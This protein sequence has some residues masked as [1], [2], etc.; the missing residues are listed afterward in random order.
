MKQ[1]EILIHATH[2]NDWVHESKFPFV[3][4]IGFIRS[5]LSD[6]SAP[7]YGATDGAAFNTRSITPRHGGPTFMW[8]ALLTPAD[9][10]GGRLV[11]CTYGFTAAVAPPPPPGLG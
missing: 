3:S 1:T 5:K 9:S 10:A 8:G 4:R 6:F 2:V 7:V 11:V